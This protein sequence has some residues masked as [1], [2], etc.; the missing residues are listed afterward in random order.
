MMEE[1][2]QAKDNID[3]HILISKYFGW[4]YE[5]KCDDD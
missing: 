3:K 4:N 2:L 1:L 5:L